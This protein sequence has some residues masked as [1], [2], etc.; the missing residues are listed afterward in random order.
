MLSTTAPT[1]GVEF[2]MPSILWRVAILSVVVPFYKVGSYIE[3]CLL[4]V[5][6]QTLRDLQV[7]LVDDGSTDSSIEVAQRFVRDDRRFQLVVQENAG[8]GPARN[9]GTAMADGEFITFVD[10][11]DVVAPRAYSHLVGSLQSTGSDVA[12]GNTSRFGGKD[13]VVPSW[14]HAGSFAGTRLSTRLVDSPDLARDRM[15]WNKVYR[16]SFWDRHA[17]EFPAIR[18]E[19]WP[20][21][22]GAYLAADAVDQLSDVVYY[23]RD[24]ASGDSITQQLTNVDNARDRLTSAEL[25][26][27]QVEGQDADLV[28]R[29]E[30]E[31][32]LAEV[33]L[34]A[35]A[36]ALGSMTAP[37]RTEIGLRTVA[38][39]RRLSPGILDFPSD[40]ERSVA[41]VVRSIHNAL[42][43]GNIDLASA[44]GTAR[45]GGGIRPLVRHVVRERD[46]LGAS[47]AA[48]VAAGRV[49]RRIPQGTTRRLRVH[50]E[51]SR[52]TS[53]GVELSM[54]TLLR[55]AVASR[56]RASATWGEDA[57]DLPVRVE[58]ERL[59]VTVSDALLTAEPTPITV[60][61]RLGPARWRGPL[62]VV[63][64]Q[65]LGLLGDDVCLASQQ[66][67]EGRLAEQAVTLRRVSDPAV[68]SVKAV[69]QGLRLTGP[70]AL[71]VEIPS[72]TE[73]LELP[74]GLVPL[75]RLAEMDP[76][77]NPVVGVSSRRVLSDGRPCF[78]AGGGSSVKVRT[79]EASLVATSDFDGHLVLRTS[80]PALP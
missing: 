28:V 26:M 25:V 13:G 66:I 12:A 69:D 72:P 22:L 70:S 65:R 61:L 21:T 24:R 76:S 37:D 5:Q 52:A 68:V 18:Y 17:F 46:R 31:A 50:L 2:T 6:R 47:A 43:G 62:T 75:R 11:D 73:D 78:L 63:E 3:S 74:D 48:Q 41:P 39:S 60:E 30:V 80:T 10:S 36:R 33:D 4:S 55:D 8:L 1:V 59:M 32:L 49:R 27:D 23:W 40:P 51:S 67:S 44:L 56:C 15:V 79:E 20:V 58:G 77:D 53:A 16:R 14:T 19:D 35:L 64:P 7:I 57:V 45:G 38:L 9:S 71:R 54:V 29:E 34:V 42:R